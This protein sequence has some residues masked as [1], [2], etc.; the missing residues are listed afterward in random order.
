MKKLLSAVLCCFSLSAAAGIQVDATRVIYHGNAQ[1]ASLNIH[2]DK[3]ETY[4]VQTWLDQGD[5]TK[6]PQDIPVQVIPPVLK[7]A[8]NKEAVLRFIYSG[9]G[10][11]QDRE[12]LFWV[13]VQEIP[14]TSS[15]ENVLQIAVR[16]RIKLF[17]R[18]DGLNTTLEKQ[19]E[20]LKWHRQGNQLI[21]ENSGPL[22]ITLGTV[23]LTSGSGK[24]QTIDA[25]MIKPFDHATMTL[26]AGTENGSR[27]GFSYINDYGGNSQVNNISL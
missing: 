23:T 16:T 24:K 13:N 17:Y 4:M 10:L 1:S 11:P 5:A 12:S 15:K 3:P 21:V 9:K 26:P 18:P 27:I 22:N 20:A 8:G 19:A 7:L 25:D 2:N 6:T 14:P